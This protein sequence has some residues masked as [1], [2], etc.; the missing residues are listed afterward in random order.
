M[1]NKK[2]IV[3]IAFILLLNLYSIMALE[4]FQTKDDIG[5][6]SVRIHTSIFYSDHD[7]TN[8]YVS[9]GKPLEVAI[10]YRAYVETWN[11]LNIYNRVSFCNFTVSYSPR[12][13]NS[14]IVLFNKMITNDYGTA[15][16]FVPLRINEEAY[17]DM[18]C[19]FSGQVP[20]DLTVP[21]EVSVNTPTWECKACQMYE[22][23][24]QQRSI[25]KAESLGDTT[26]N[27]LSY[28]GQLFVINFQ[29]LISLFWIALIFIF[30]YSF[31][32]IFDVMIFLIKY[33][34]GI[35]K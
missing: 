4:F 19:K 3:G 15:Q 2:I 13:F 29:I 18:V 33:L 6:G 28:I 9:S 32:L 30:L 24:V 8:N 10:N 26:I 22:W 27:I 11:S 5:N 16:Y 17:A 35:G 20:Y 31:S 34:Q 14:T 12:Y 21:S 1:K 25:A 7:L 23:Q